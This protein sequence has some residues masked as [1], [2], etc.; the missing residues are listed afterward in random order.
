MDSYEQFL[1]ALKQKLDYDLSGYKRKQMERR[2]NSL[3]GVLGFADNYDEFVEAIRK[4]EQIC[5]RFLDYITIN[6]SEFF[7]NP[8]QWEVLQN[9]ILPQLLSKEKSLSFWSAGCAT[10]EEPYSLAIIMEEL[11]P[12]QKYSILATDCDHGVLQKA[13]EG[14]YLA[15]SVQTIPDKYVYKYFLTKGD[16]Y[17]IKDELKKKIL[18]RNHNLLRDEFPKRIDLILCRNVVIYF[19]EEIK[20]QLYFKFYDALRPGGFLLTGSTEQIIQVKKIGFE[21]V[22]S[23]FYRRP[24]L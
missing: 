5:H 24:L 19:K 13:K 11:F 8:T 10:G 18:F 7:R 20:E 23:F 14:F 1:L 3:M 9:K 4:D 12:A 15:R 22:T 2:I 21:T 6:V 16:R 17:C